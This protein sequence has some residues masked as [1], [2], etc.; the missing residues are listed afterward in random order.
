MDD[1]FFGGNVYTVAKL[2][3]KKHYLLVNK[4]HTTI[5]ICVRTDELDTLSKTDLIEWAKVQNITLDNK[6]SKEDIIN[7]LIA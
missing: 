7:K 3:D 1:T 5:G 2:K 6:T 4:L